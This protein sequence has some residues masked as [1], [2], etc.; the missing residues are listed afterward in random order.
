MNQDQVQPIMSYGQLFRMITNRDD[1]VWLQFIFY[2]VTG[3]ENIG[4]PKIKKEN[5][6]EVEIPFQ[7]VMEE[8]FNLANYAEDKHKINIWGINSD[9]DAKEL[10]EIRFV[11]NVPVSELLKLGDLEIFEDKVDF[12]F[13]TLGVTNKVGLKNGEKK[14]LFLLDFEPKFI[15]FNNKFLVNY[16]QKI[17]NLNQSYFKTIVEL[18]KD[19][20]IKKITLQDINDFLSTVLDESGGVIVKT[21]NSFHYYSSRIMTYDE[22]VKLTESLTTYSI[23]G[24]EFPRYAL[25]RDMI[26]LRIRECTGKDKPVI[27]VH[28]NDLQLN[29]FS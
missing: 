5:Y 9:S 18:L 15:K 2:E 17:I 13:W 7:V 6:R 27:I 19:K 8:S 25:L 12:D 22:W 3:Y 16:I 24:K 28:I 21:Q 29:L 4:P 23:I 26:V 14:Y 1:I 10:E 11:F 20:L